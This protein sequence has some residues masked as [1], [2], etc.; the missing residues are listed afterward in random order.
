MASEL[1]L[2]SLNQLQKLAQQQQQYFNPRNW[3]GLRLAEADDDSWKVRAF[4]ESATGM[5]WPLRS[6][7]CT[8]CRREFRSAQ[9]LGGHMNVHRRDRARL[10]Q[11]P[12]GSHPSSP[13]TPSPPI[14]FP[15]PV[16]EFVS[17]GRCYCLLYPIPDAATIIFA[18]TRDSPSTLLYISPYPGNG[19]GGV[20][21]DEGNNG[22]DVDKELDL[23][24]RLGW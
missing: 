14:V 6:Y 21:K 24:L 7:T 19:S 13:T 11:S 12:Q 4:A 20:D 3:P 18:P 9:A 5:T 1:S 16:P 22:D 10:L 2:L 17:G 23:E 8:F 15:P